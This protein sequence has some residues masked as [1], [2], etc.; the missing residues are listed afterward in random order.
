MPE[1]RN[2]L[3]SQSLLFIMTH[4]LK[5]W[6]EFF[7]EVLSRVKKFEYRQTRDRTF[8]VGDTL[9]LREWCPKRKEYTG[10]TCTRI[11]TYC[12]FVNGRCCSTETVK[13][14]VIMSIS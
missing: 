10:L 9:L 4:D 7:T 14:F 1:L 13:P 6:P 11:V 3:Y 5:I 2:E 8:A 12:L